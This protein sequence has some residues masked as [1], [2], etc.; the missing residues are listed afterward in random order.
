[1]NGN[2]QINSYVET[3]NLELSTNGDVEVKKRLG[4]AQ[5]GE[6]VM[7]GGKLKIGSAF[8]CMAKLPPTTWDKIA[9]LEEQKMQLLCA[10]K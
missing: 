3:Q 9:D 4:I 2:I 7:G 8:A 5:R 10:E 1:M 6:I